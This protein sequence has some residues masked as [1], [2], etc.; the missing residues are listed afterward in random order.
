MIT[1][2]TTAPQAQTLERKQSRSS[3][4]DSLQ[5]V[6]SKES[7]A[8]VHVSDPEKG[9][10]ASGMVEDDDPSLLTRL[11][12]RFR[13]FVLIALAA[14]ILAW[15]ICSTVLEATRHRWIVQTFWAWFFLIRDKH[16]D[17]VANLSSGDRKLEICERFPGTF[18]HC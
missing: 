1:Q 11:Y 16:R 4:S 3:G 18:R 17:S 14:L 2:E 9:E 6:H 7:P 12:R 15:W 10:H 5:K 13:P 8:D